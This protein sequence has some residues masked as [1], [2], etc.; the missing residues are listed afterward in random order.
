MEAGLQAP[1]QHVDQDEP[2]VLLVSNV[3]NAH[4][5]E[6]SY[7]AHSSVANYP[8]YSI[9]SDAAGSTPGTPLK[10]ELTTDTSLYTITPNFVFVTVPLS[11]KDLRRLQ[12]AGLSICALAIRS[13]TM[14]GRTSCCSVG[15]RD[16]WC[17]LRM[18][19]FNISPLWHNFQFLINWLYT[20]TLWLLHITRG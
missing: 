3:L 2:H 12:G 15:P 16:N 9:S 20:A 13:S 18:C 19:S 6:E 10:V 14:A 1:T 8:F 4:K 5:F 17:Q 11:V 7:R